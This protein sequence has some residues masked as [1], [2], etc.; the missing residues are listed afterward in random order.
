M[1]AVSG[2]AN[3]LPTSVV[4]GVARSQ[5]A[6]VDFATS[7]VRGAPIEVYVAG[8]K[9][10]K[11]YPMGPVAGTAWNI[12]MMSYAGTLNVGVHIDPAAVADPELLMRS[13]KEGYAELT[14]AGGQS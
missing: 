10:L 14:N 1:G 3:L 12:T 8:G 11:A 2:I 9:A 5:A 13:L 7:N 4:T 6:A